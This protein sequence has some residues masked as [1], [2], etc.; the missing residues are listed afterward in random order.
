MRAS[1]TH[2][3]VAPAALWPGTRSYEAYFALVRPGSAWT[4]AGSA[5]R[6]LDYM[7]AILVFRSRYSWVV[8]SSMTAR[9]IAASALSFN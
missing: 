8:P 5:E 9:L 4:R 6:K 7:A 3:R 2:R 1:L